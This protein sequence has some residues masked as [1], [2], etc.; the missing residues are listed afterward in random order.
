MTTK[1]VLQ[2]RRQARAIPKAHDP[3]LGVLREVSN[4]IREARS[5]ALA[6][7][8]NPDGDALGSMLAL[9]IAIKRRSPSKEV[10]V[11]SAD[12]VPEI[13]CFLPGASLIRRNTELRDF[14]LAIALDSGDLSRIGQSLVPVFNTAKKQIDIDHHVGEG[15]FGDIR[16]LDSTAAATAEIVFE[17][18]QTLGTPI[19]ADIA[20]CLLTGVITD[21]GSFRFMN[22]TP[23]TL[24]TSAILIE[25]GASPS[26]ISERVFDNRTFGATRLM[27]N[28]LSS[29]SSSEDGRIVWAH[30]TAQDFALS[31]ATDEDTEG[32]I[33]YVRAVRGAEVAILFR[34]TSP[35]S[36]RISLRSTQ[37]VNVAQIA[38][39]FGG[40]G[41]RM[42]A[43]CSY[44]G[45]LAEAEAAIVGATKL[46]LPEI[47]PDDADCG[48]GPG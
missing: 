18:L 47:L 36:I 38:A 21:T 35:Q 30:I 25:A 33:N 20:T 15:A 7:H 34:E 17:L 3:K 11:L 14:D 6:C 37:N 27:G 29:L 10:V 31:Q 23:R 24:R 26:A 40:G 22:V 8:V 43:G 1:S 32:F 16:L 44:N 2:G 48:C 12:G 4:A 19:D 5:V 39:Q 28:T 45:P 46:G 42:A 9:G 41:H 13:Y